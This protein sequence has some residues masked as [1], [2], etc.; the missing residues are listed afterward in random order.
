MLTGQADVSAVGKAVNNAQLYRYIQKPWSEVDLIMTINEAIQS[1]Q[2]DKKIIKQSSKLKKLVEQLRDANENLEKRVQERTNEV[3]EQKRVIELKNNE[4]TSSIEYAQR[5]QKALLPP[6]EEIINLL[7]EHFIYYQ[8]K[9]IVSGDFYWLSEKENKSIIAAADCTGHGVPGAFMSMLGISM[10]NEIVNQ[11]NIIQTD[12]I[13]NKLRENI[14]KS[15]R[16][17]NNIGQLKDGMDLSVLII[18]WNEMTVQFSGAYNSLIIVRKNELYTH[19]ADRMPVGYHSKHNN[20]FNKKEIK[21]EHDDILY[22][23]SDGYI[24]QFG[25]NSNKKFLIQQF[26]ALLLEINSESLVKQ[27]EIIN[28]KFFEWKGSNPQTDDILIIGIKI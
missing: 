28:K 3:V 19:K 10:L 12:I 8:P 7:R 13:L 26:K 14:I 22:I 24:D 1:Y 9:D 23:F 20:S 2:K 18:N 21:L 25:G 16:Q 11:Q 17:N 6:D 5:I 27:K 4:I 15:L